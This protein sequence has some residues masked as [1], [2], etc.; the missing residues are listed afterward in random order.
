[1]PDQKRIFPYLL[2]LNFLSTIF[3]LLSNFTTKTPLFQ[4]SLFP[5]FVR[6]PSLS[7][8]QTSKEKYF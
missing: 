3:D 7:V 1:M 5:Y 8:V 2:G 4:I 6:C